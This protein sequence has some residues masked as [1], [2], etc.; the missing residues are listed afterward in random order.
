MNL[1][2]YDGA[3]EEPGAAFLCLAKSSRFDRNRDPHC[4]RFGTAFLN[5][6]PAAENRHTSLLAKD[7]T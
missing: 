4:R 7:R 1:P 2:E 6:E 5:S 3:G